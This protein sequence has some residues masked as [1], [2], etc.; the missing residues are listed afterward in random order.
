MTAPVTEP[1]NKRSEPD[2][3]TLRAESRRVRES[4]VPAYE[5]GW[6]AWNYTEYPKARQP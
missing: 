4:V 3:T 1:G 6:R 2:W 5:V